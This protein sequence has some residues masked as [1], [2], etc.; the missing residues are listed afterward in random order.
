MATTRL[1]ASTGLRICVAHGGGYI[2]GYWGRMDH[3][4]RAR[5]DSIYIALGGEWV[6][7]H[8]QCTHL[9]CPVMYERAADEGGGV[10]HEQLQRGERL[11]ADALIG[12]FA[13]AGVDAIDRGIARGDTGDRLGAA[14]H[15]RAA[16]RIEPRIRAAIDCAPLLERHCAGFERD[17]GRPPEMRA[18][19]GLN[20]MR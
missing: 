13:K 18:W 4:W 1:V 6:A 17:H 16:G 3:G 11:L 14:L 15:R 12:Q 5:G 8:Q 19:S 20:P 2:P 10:G 9:A 7:Y